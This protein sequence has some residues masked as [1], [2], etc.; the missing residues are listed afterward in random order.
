MHENGRV[1]PHD[2]LVEAG[3]GFPPVLANVE[4]KLYAI[5]PIVIH[6][7]EPIVEFAAGEYESVLLAVGGEVLEKVFS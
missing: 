7:G 1:E 6:R 2:V 5:L 3:H 4:L